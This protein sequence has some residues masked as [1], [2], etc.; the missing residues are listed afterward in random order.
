MKSVAVFCGSSPTV[1][2]KYLQFGRE[3]GI[4]LAQQN[5]RLVYGGAK[6][7]VMGATA[8]GCLQNG[9]QVLGVIPKLLSAKEVI[10][11]KVQEMTVVNDMHQRKQK[12][13]EESQAFVILPGGW[14]TLD[15]F[16]EIATW[17]QLG[18]HAK[19]ILIANVEGFYAPLK[20]FFQQLVREKFLSD[21]QLQT[22]YWVNDREQ[23]HRELNKCL[24][25]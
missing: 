18:Y 3:L 1:S 22:L 19:P 21:L 4:F 15:E 8:D 23:L 12:M 7:G 5:Y 9:G 2:E 14:G 17:S 13:Y 6:I 10:H 24:M 20:D 25:S 11:P 16:M